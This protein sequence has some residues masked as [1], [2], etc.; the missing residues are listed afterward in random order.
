MTVPPDETITDTH[1]IIAALRTERDA[2]L[3]REAT[4]AEVLATRTAELAT[5]NSEYG[6]RIQQQAATI[7]VLKA[8]SASPGDPQPVFD[9]ITRRATE[10]CE[11]RAALYELREGQLDV[12]ASHGMDLKTI[13]AFRRNF[14]R[15]PDRSLAVGR[16]ILERRIIHVRDVSADP[17]LSQAARDLGGTAI[18]VIP[19]L[20]DGE[21][22][23]AVALNGRHAGGYSESQIALL[24]TFAEQAMIAIGNAE[25]YRALQGRTAD[26][27]E[28][29]EY[30]TATSD[31]LKVISRSTFDLD[32]V[33]QAVVTTAVRLCRADQATIYRYQDG[34]YHW[35][36]GFGLAPDYERIERESRILPGTGTLVGRVALQGRT[37]QIIDAWTDPLY[38]AK[39]DARLGG[40]RTMLGV[41][42][43]RDGVP[44]GVIGLARRR[45]EPYTER[46]IALVSTF[47]EQGVIAIGSVATF[48][49][50]QERTAELTR[51]VAELQALEEVLRA[52]NSSLDLDTVLDTIISRA[53]QLSQA[54]EG[55]IYEYDEA[56]EVFVPMAAFGM[57]EERVLALRERRVRLGETHLGRAAVQRAPVHI[58]DVQQDPSMPGVGELLHGIH[59]VLAVPLLRDEKVIGGLVI[60]RR[61]AGDFAPTIATLLQ[62][63]AGQSVLAIENARLFQ[64]A[65]RARATAEIALTDLR[66]AQANLIQAEKMA[67][68]GQLTAG[69]AHEI[70]NPLN[71]V[72]NFA[73]LSVELLSE[74]KQIATT[75]LASLESEQRAEVAEVIGLLTSNLE[76]ITEHGKRADG[77]VKSMLE[78]S[79]GASG[80]RRAVDMNTLADEALHLAYHGARAQDQS[81]S[82]SLERDFGEGIAPIEV[83]PQ[84]ITRVL[85]N[86]FSNGFYA[87]NERARSGAEPRS[88]PTMKVTTRDLGAVI[89]VRVRDNGTGVPTEIRDKLFE[90]F[91]TTKP[92]GEGTG[93]GLSITYDIVTK[94]HGGTITVDSEVDE[95]TEFVVTLPRRMFA[96]EGDRA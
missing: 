45:I 47:A 70:K 41:P 60:R 87:A 95:F 66:R 44:I 48:Q 21:P 5:R 58:S 28:L 64:E 57:T 91:F 61:T 75:A 34:K 72:N 8:M 78:H 14:P 80:E 27:R 68:L 30:Q 29:L 52:V 10:L 79:R 31:V 26:L 23:G 32:P 84:D 17:T 88:D 38:E 20:R 86:L 39:E 85:L 59:A 65:R 83:N 63:F 9:L 96:T 43:L 71:F 40:V 93:L 7:D 11:L 33:F 35:A 90:P 77:I 12:V 42:L 54:D 49:A 92:T 4:L 67:S 1:A 53:V 22:I 62:T 15:P 2:A 82:I 18:A 37:V 89:E 56:E 94:Q 36:A 13:A 19:L 69:I 3:A 76:K 55:T 50:L 16:A 46:Q 51:S 81:F 24:Q 6:E 25:T 74:L 73:I